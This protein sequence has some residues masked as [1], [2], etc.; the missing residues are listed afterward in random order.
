MSGFSTLGTA[1]AVVAACNDKVTVQGMS[2]V[3]P[4]EICGTNTG[5]HSKIIPIIPFVNSFKNYTMSVKWYIDS[6]GAFH[7]LHQPDGMLYSTFLYHLA[8]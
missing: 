6:L 4:P 1:G 3:N 8:D 2:G 7:I 5:Y